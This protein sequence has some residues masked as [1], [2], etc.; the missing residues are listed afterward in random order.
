MALWNYGRGSLETFWDWE[1]SLFFFGWGG[2]GGAYNMF[3]N[4]MFQLI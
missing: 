3:L 2:V 4:K 1:K